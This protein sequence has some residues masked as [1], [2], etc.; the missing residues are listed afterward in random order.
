MANEGE[1]SERPPKRT[2]RL[3][4]AYSCQPAA[5]DF[6]KGWEIRIII[7]AINRV[8]SVP[9]TMWFKILKLWDHFYILPR[10]I[11]FCE[12]REEKRKVVFPHSLY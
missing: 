6:E 2:W 5:V 8:L 10:N 3:T 7:S 4:I 11:F 12:S 9:E 1:E